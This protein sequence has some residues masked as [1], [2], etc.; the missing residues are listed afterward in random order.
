MRLSLPVVAGLAL[1]ILAVSTR[2]AAQEGPAQPIPYSHKIHAGDLQL[3]CS[4]CHVNPDPGETMTLPKPAVCG[5]CHPGKY[6]RDFKWV[7]VYEIP[8]FVFFSH[9]AHVKAGNTCVECHGPVASRARLSRETDLT[10]GGCM[11]CH[12]QKKASID[13]TFC[14]DQ[15]N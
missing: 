14:H 11:N 1:L 7:R 4:S 12:R 9:R 2:V 5:T 3:E 15:R 13:C 8:S 6:D 10:M